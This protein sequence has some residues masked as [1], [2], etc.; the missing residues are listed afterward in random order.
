MFLFPFKNQNDCLCYPDV[1][2]VHSCGLRALWVCSWMDGWMEVL[3]NEMILMQLLMDEIN[4]INLTLATLD[5]V[6]RP[7]WQAAV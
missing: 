7:L 3:L 1:N 4:L 2:T 6:K 5:R